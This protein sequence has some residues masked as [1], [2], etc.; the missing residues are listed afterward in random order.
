MFSSRTS[1]RASLA[2][3]LATTIAF[4][5]PA[6]S[7]AAVVTFDVLVH[8]VDVPSAGNPQGIYGG[9][10]TAGDIDNPDTSLDQEIRIERSISNQVVGTGL[11]A[12]VA[13]VD[14]NLRAHASGFWG[15]S[16]SDTNEPSQAATALIRVRDSFVIAGPG[17]ALS[18]DFMV[19]LHGSILANGGNA[20]WFMAAYLAQG[21]IGAD[22]EDSVE[23]RQCRRARFPAD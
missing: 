15:A 3:W 9:L 1:R 18:L 6:V 4:I 8:S 10:I 12:R 19:N 23:L 16:Y 21:L 20:S 2:A 5:A 17:A 14:G 22:P 7:T 13:W 11:D